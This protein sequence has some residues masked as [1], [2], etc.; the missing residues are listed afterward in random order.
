MHFHGFRLPFNGVS[1]CIDHNEWIYPKLCTDPQI[2]WEQCSMFSDP[3]NHSLGT[4]DCVQGYEFHFH[5]VKWWWRWWLMTMMM[6]RM[7]MT[8]TAWSSSTAS[9]TI[10]SIFI[11]LGC[12]IFYRVYISRGMVIWSTG[13]YV[14]KKY[15]RHPRWLKLGLLWIRDSWPIVLGGL[16]WRSSLRAPPRA[17][18]SEMCH[19]QLFGQFWAWL[20]EVSQSVIGGRLRSINQSWACLSV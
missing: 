4:V 10:S 11:K 9:Q 20:R 8:M 17:K 7:T 14:W 19:F 16:M 18:I 5:Q 12:S 1:W 13:L 15:C 3:A 6:R 2:E